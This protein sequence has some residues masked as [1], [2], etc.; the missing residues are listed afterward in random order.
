MCFARSAI[1]ILT[2]A[3]W[4]F[5]AASAAATIA[6]HDIVSRSATILSSIGDLHTTSPMVL[7][8]Q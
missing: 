2:H 4:A 6:A 3:R 5:R 7:F 1:G 8:S